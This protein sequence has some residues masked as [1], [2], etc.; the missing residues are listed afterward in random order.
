MQRNT[1]YE[2]WASLCTLEALLDASPER[3]MKAGNQKMWR[4]LWDDA[5][6]KIAAYLCRPPAGT[7]DDESFA[8]EL[9]AAERT[10]LR[11]E[12]EK[13]ST[14]NAEAG[15]ALW[16]NSATIYMVSTNIRYLVIALRAY[17]EQ[18]RR[19]MMPTKGVAL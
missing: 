9:L 4:I 14:F 8:E 11:N 15:E 13:I 12:I 18:E 2:M 5:S 3:G 7:A 17:V 16:K 1:F 10:K 19:Y 6:G